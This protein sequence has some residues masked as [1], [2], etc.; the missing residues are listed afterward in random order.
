MA[1]F[2]DGQPVVRGRAIEAGRRSE[3]SISSAFTLPLALS[4]Q[5]APAPSVDHEPAMTAPYVIC[6]NNGCMSYYEAKR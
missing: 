6:F 2:E 1:G 3:K 4:L 5:P